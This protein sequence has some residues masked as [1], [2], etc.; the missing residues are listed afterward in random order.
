M[1]CP[2]IIKKYEDE[3]DVSKDGAKS[4][5]GAKRGKPKGGKPAKKAKKVEESEDED[6]SDGE[7]EY[8]VQKVL[9]VRTK[10]NGSREFL[11][12]WKGWSSRFD[13][14]EP[15]DN[16]NCDKLIADF[17]SKLEK[18]KNSSQKELRIAPKTTKRFTSSSHRAGGVR[19]S[20]RGGG[21][22]RVTYF[23]ED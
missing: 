8:E 18:A 15:E 11:V 5:G 10:K 19:A 7:K 22:E 1:S 3:N 20:K 16:L 12:H 2:D 14:W 17:D 4:G 9:D 6:D 13:S 21:K 23:D